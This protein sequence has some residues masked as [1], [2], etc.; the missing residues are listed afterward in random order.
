MTFISKTVW[1]IVALM[2]I[3]ACFGVTEGDWEYDSISG[4]VAIRKYYGTDT[5]VAIPNTLGGKTVIE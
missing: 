1:T 5:D 3:A 4:G 2:L